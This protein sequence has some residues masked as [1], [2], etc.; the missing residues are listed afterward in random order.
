VSVCSPSVPTAHVATLEL[1]FHDPHTR[2]DSSPMGYPRSHVV[3]PLRTGIYHCISRCVRRESLIESDERCTWIVAALDRLCRTFAV[4]VCDFA[5]MRNHVHLLVRTHPELAMTWSDREVARRWICRHGSSP[6]GLEASIDA[7]CLDDSLI[8]EWRSRLSDLGWF[9]KLWKEPAAKAWNREDDVTGH[10]WEGRFVSIGCQDEA[11]VLMQAT[12][13]LLNPVHCGIETRLGESGRSSMGRRIDRIRKAILAG[14]LR[15]GV[16]TYRLTLLE[17]AIPCDPGP[18]LARLADAEWS[19][20][21][22]KRTHARA[23]REAAVAEGYRSL[24]MAR[25]SGGTIPDGGRD[26]RSTHP[27][28][29]DHTHL[30]PAVKGLSRPPDHASG[31]RAHAGRNRPGLPSNPSRRRNPWRGRATLP[32]LEG[33]TLLTFI[34]FVDD[35]SR[36]PRIDKPCHIGPGN[37]RLVERLLRSLRPGIPGP[38]GRRRGRRH[39][40]EVMLALTAR[41]LASVATADNAHPQRPPSPRVN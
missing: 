38:F 37:P 6:A 19:E 22:A 7:A 14:E 36:M 13:I 20:R 27:R 12:Y 31:L 5:V 23:L 32:L 18:D 26:P 30:P 25:R 11:S 15:E 24:R 1:T 34:D 3:D 39:V 2:I 9:H 33:C 29:A 41:S 17:P 16:E 21:L 10:F 4:D 28:E 8:A 35:R 40:A